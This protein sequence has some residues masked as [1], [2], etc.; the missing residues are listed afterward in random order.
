MVALVNHLLTY[1]HALCI[2]QQR[3]PAALIDIMS[4]QLLIHNPLELVQ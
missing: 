1:L 3:Q 2:M 4:I